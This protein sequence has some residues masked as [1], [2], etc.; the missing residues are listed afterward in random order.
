MWYIFFFTYAHVASIKVFTCSLYFIKA[1]F[2]LVQLS[3]AWNMAKTTDWL[4]LL[5]FNYFFIIIIILLFIF[6][7]MKLYEL[8]QVCNN[9]KLCFA[10]LCM[11]TWFLIQMGKFHKPS[12]QGQWWTELAF[13]WL[14]SLSEDCS[15]WSNSKSVET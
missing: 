9:T 7:Q 15:H 10:D 3:F 6:N 14:I 8:V 4:I 13:C 11:A 1:V 5:F 2:K 12:W